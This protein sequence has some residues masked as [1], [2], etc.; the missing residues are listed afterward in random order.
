MS[1][2]TFYVQL[3][4]R[5]GLRYPYGDFE[6]R[7]QLFLP[8]DA[9]GRVDEDAI[10]Q[11]GDY[12]GIRFRA[13]DGEA[14]GRIVVGSGGRLVLEYDDLRFYPSILRLGAGTITAGNFVQIAEHDGQLYNCRITS[15]RDVRS[16]AVAV[17]H[18]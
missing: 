9:D 18:V 1:A 7:Y 10:R 12:R 2:Y 3:E 17:A 4:S 16:P 5:S 6:C 8:L 11:G 13:S 15:A 14:V